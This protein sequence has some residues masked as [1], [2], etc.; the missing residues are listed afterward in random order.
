MTIKVA[1]RSPRYPVIGLREAV[2]KVSVVYKADRRN[3]IPKHLVAEHL[4]YS[5]L[6]GK[7]LGIISAITKYGLLDGG[8]DSMWVTDRAVDILE[9]ERGDPE[10]TQAIQEAAQ[11][12]D[13]YKE[14]DEAFPDK[15]SDAAIRAFLITKRQFLPESAERLVRSYRETREFVES[16]LPV[17]STSVQ[18]AEVVNAATPSVSDHSVPLVGPAVSS[19]VNPPRFYGGGSSAVE[20]GEREWLRGPLSKDTSYRLV[21]T[22]IMGPKE[23]GKLIKLLEAQKIILEDDDE[24]D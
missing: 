6:N 12:P 7:S 8:R 1:V 3:K 23:I 19:L 18:A 10:R 5:G 22:G 14:V 24:E 16:E 13:L 20:A 2:E 21:V 4:G 9:R 15:A 11:E 17:Q